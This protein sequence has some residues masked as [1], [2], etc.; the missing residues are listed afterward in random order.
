MALLPDIHGYVRFAFRRLSAE[1]REEAVQE[2]LANALVAY[3]RLY[4][5]SK[6]DLAHATP[7]ARCAVRQVCGGRAGRRP[8]QRLRDALALRPAQAGLRCQP[9]ASGRCL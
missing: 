7:L 4:E 2:A 9:T 3:R 1:R 8:A 6:T 5:L